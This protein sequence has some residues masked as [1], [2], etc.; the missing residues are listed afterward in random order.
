MKKPGRILTEVL[1]H[2]FKKPITTQYP[3][4]KAEIPDRFRGKVVSFDAKCVG[5]KIC[6]RDC[7]ADAITLTKVAEKQFE[8]SIDLAK[9]IYCAQC[10]DSCPRKVL[11]STPEFE[12]AAL[13]RATLKVKINVEE[14]IA[15]TASA[16]PTSSAQ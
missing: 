12:L 13:D 1:P 4:V 2:A 7:P 5:C 8:I 3:K 15:K 10:V 14:P 11:V 9:C 16:E 6:M